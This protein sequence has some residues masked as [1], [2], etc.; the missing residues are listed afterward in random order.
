MFHNIKEPLLTKWRYT[1]Y[2]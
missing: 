2:S 1:R